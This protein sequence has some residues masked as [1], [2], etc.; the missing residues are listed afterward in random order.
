VLSF[1]FNILL[2]IETV[3][4]RRVSKEGNCLLFVSNNHK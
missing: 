3:K 4:D 2:H 1:C